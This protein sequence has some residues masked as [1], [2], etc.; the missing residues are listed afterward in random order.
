M[1]IDFHSILWLR[2]RN[3]ASQHLKADTPPD[4]FGLFF[5]PRSGHNTG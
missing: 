1:I 2:I 3:G 4:R 5:C